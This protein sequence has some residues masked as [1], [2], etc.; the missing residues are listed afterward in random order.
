MHAVTF[1]YCLTNV[2]NCYVLPIWFILE[3]YWQKDFTCIELDH[4]FWITLS[5]RYLVST[6]YTNFTFYWAFPFSNCSPLLP[7]WQILKAKI[8]FE[9]ALWIVANPTVTSEVLRLLRASSFPSW[10]VWSWSFPLRMLK[11]ALAF[12]LS[13]VAECRLFATL[14]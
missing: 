12:H 9:E 14:W 2:R 7:R 8:S 4:H 5:Y 13:L 3:F 11:V 1:L 10:S 6:F